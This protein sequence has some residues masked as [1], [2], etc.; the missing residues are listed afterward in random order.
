MLSLILAAPSTTPYVTL[1]N[2]VQMPAVAAG[3]WQYTT[4]YAQSSV[5]SA[6]K[7]GFTHID[8]A[9]DYCA[10]GSTGDCSAV[11]GSNQAGIAKAL[12]ASGLARES[13]FVT[14][15]VPGCGRQ[16]VSFDNCAADSVK[17]A[18]GNLDEL[19]TDYVDLL[20]VHFPPEGGCGPKNCAAIKQQWAALSALVAQNKT[21]ALGVSNFCV[22]C[23]ECLSQTA[24]AIVPA[25]NQ[26][27]FHIG[28]SAD[29]EGLVS[30][31]KAHGI[32]A[33]AY[34]PLG[35]NT[36]E[37]ITG[38]L[39]TALGAAH[40]KSGVQVALRWIW[41]HGVAPTTKSGNPVHLA[42]D[43]DLFDWQ[44]T[45]DEMARADAATDPAGTPSFMCTA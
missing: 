26:F 9:H 12:A 19:E 11:G 37:L 15:K 5:A 41:Q 25:V 40:N 14:T 42:Q 21:R 33:Q 29:P 38:P 3:T 7:V 20:L 45:S 4:A 30:Y 13:V 2:G 23:L 6:F 8:T 44:L 18:Q 10:D 32:A 16:G 22:S 39:V 43:L 27:K 24:G 35:D 17:A 1:N 31:C 28:M 34:S 36:T